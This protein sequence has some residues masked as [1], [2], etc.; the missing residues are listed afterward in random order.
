MKGRR[1]TGRSS[2]S[3]DT[4]HTPTSP[5]GVRDRVPRVP[6]VRYCWIPPLFPRLLP[7]SRAP[8][9]TPRLL[10]YASDTGTNSS[11][12]LSTRG[13]KFVNWLV[14]RRE[15]GT[16][17][18]VFVHSLVTPDELSTRALRRGF[19]R[20]TKEERPMSNK[21]GVS[22]FGTRGPLSGV[23]RRSRLRKCQ[24]SH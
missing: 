24:V 23:I 19:V 12:S 6:F 18:R 20:T 9:D 22:S 8:V 3:S 17:D 15:F 5:V 7:Y 2:S 13:L 16:E 14:V 1:Q 10:P 4:V 21:V 11:S